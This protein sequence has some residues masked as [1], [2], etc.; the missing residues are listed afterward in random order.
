MGRN[1]CGRDSPGSRLIAWSS[2]SSGGL[3]AACNSTHYFCTAGT[4]E[5]IQSAEPLRTHS[6]R[7]PTVRRRAVPAGRIDLPRHFREALPLAAEADPRLRAVAEDL[8]PRLD[9][10]RIIE[11]PGHDHRDVRHDLGLVDQRRSALRTESA[12]GCLAAVAPTRERLQRA[13]HAQRRRRESNHDGKGSPGTL[14]AVLAV[15]DADEGR[16][17]VGRI[18]YLTAQATTFDLHPILLCSRVHSRWQKYARQASRT[19]IRNRVPPGRARD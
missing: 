13:M 6:R 18:A 1:R 11:R 19:T 4:R 16:F 14:L 12:V 3:P 17:G 5:S 7:G 2:R 15:A 8:H 9:P 10:A